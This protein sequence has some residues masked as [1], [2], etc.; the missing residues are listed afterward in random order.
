[1]REVKEEEKGRTER[2]KVGVCGCGGGGG[3]GG[4]AT[5]DTSAW[6]PFQS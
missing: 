6:T 4:S 5:Y 1:M 3:D 2:G